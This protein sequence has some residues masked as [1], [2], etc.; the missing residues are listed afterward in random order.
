MVNGGGRIEREYALGTGR[1]DLLVLWSHAGGE[2]RFVIECKVLYGGLAGTVREGLEQTAGY[3]D[4]CGA[5]EGHLVLFDPG[6]RDWQQKVFHRRETL[7]GVPIH[8]WGC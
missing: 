4:R 3:M 2:Q 8:V 6:K 5:Q 7:R 1:A